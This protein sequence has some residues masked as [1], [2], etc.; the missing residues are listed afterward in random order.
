MH[1]SSSLLSAC[2]PFLACRL[3]ICSLSLSCRHMSSLPKRVLHE[4]N[5]RSHTYRKQFMELGRQDAH[6]LIGFLELIR[7]V[8]M[9]KVVP[10]DILCLYTYLELQGIYVSSCQL[11]KCLTTALKSTRGKH[12]K[13][14]KKS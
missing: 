3:F 14:E 5:P 8:R 13:G 7:R 9:P 11:F 12:Y 2:V 6:R 10:F 1:H 4:V